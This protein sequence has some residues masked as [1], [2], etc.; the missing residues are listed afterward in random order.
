M[1]LAGFGVGVAVAV[2]AVAVL[3]FGGRKEEP[4]KAGPD[5]VLSWAGEQEEPPRELLSAWVEFLKDDLARAAN[6]LNNRLNVIARLAENLAEVRLTREEKADAQQI[7]SEVQRAAKITQGLLRR[8]TG[9]APGEVPA[10]YRELEVSPPARPVHILVVEDDAANRSVITKLF[11]KLGHRVTA[12]SDGYE[13]FHFLQGTRVDC[14]VCDLHMSSVGGRTL[15]EQVEELMPPLSRR[16]VFATGD[17]TR[18]SSREFLE[19]SGCPIVAKPYAVEELLGA[20]WSVL[21]KLPVE[22]DE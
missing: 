6:A 16:F 10:A 4:T 7:L 8:V 22:K 9:L 3:R 20:V 17:F 18:P 12:V 2:L 1:L 21:S 14:I 11:T 19:Q 5:D 13:A 15:F